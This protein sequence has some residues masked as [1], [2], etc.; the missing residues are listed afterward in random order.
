MIAVRKGVYQEAAAQ[1]LVDAM[2]LKDKGR[3][4]TAVY[5]SGFV[6]ECMLAYAYCDKYPQVQ[7]LQD[8]PDY[9]EKIWFSHNR[10][11]EKAIKSGFN[12]Y[13]KEFSS[14]QQEWRVEM[15]YYPDHFG[16]KAGA[17]KAEKLFALA[18]KLYKII[19]NRSV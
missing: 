10:L 8:A 15:R 7:Y 6:L 18:L 12:K 1:R 14:F 9:D 2:V 3:W 16:G 19:K 11:V 17:E 13:M 5:L 4:H